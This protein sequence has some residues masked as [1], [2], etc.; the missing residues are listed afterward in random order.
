MYQ[1]HNYVM[2]FPLKKQECNKYSI[3]NSIFFECFQERLEEKYLLQSW[4][5]IFPGI[6]CVMY[7]IQSECSLDLPAVHCGIFL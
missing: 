6:N 7:T 4:D 3:Y 5:C 1:K 2:S